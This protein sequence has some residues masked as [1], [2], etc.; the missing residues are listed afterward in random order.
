[1]VDNVEQA[2]QAGASHNIFS[3]I[4]NNQMIPHPIQQNNNPKNFIN[5]NSLQL[6]HNNANLF[7]NTSPIQQIPYQKFNGSRSKAV[8]VE[9]LYD[10]RQHLQKQN[11]QLMYQSFNTAV[12]LNRNS[13]IRQKGMK[14][15]V[16]LSQNLTASQNAQVS[17]LR[18]RG[19]GNTN[20][21]HF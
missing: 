6:S 10:N 13:P 9:Q 14:Q 5:H 11:N 7:E 18:A 2:R 16:Q 4:A 12:V 20:I 21:S 1:M 15:Q 17:Q 8:P 3:P 19:G